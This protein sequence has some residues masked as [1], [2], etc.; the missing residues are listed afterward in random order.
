MG[1]KIYG[2]Q[3]ANDLGMPLATV[4]FMIHLTNV[5][6]ADICQSKE[7]LV[8]ISP[9][10]GARVFGGM[11]AVCFPFWGLQLALYPC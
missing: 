1:A 10:L 7:F 9:F 4:T 5:S 3:V 2:S 11:G 6:Q 8:Q